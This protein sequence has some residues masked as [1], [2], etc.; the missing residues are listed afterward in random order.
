MNDNP[1]P[2]GSD[3]SLWVSGRDKDEAQKKA[4]AKFPNKSFTLEQDPDV[5]D[6]WF[7]SQLVPFSSLGWP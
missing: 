1:S 6:T 3:D 5:F 7:S 4:E 2:F